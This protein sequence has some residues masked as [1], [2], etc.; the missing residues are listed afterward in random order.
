MPLRPA[1]RMRLQSHGTPGSSQ[2]ARHSRRVRDDSVSRSSRSS[3]GT[4]PALSLFLSF[5]L[6]FSSS[7]FLLLSSAR[8]ASV[9]FKFADAFL[10][11]LAIRIPD[12]LGGEGRISGSRRKTSKGM[13]DRRRSTG[14][15]D[16]FASRDLAAREI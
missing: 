4:S 10:A 3:P 16:S 2:C 1:S 13:S 14:V 11:S 12:P 8:R 9:I 7:C 5:L 6:V 15:A